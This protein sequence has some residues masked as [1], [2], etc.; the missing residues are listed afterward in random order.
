MQGTLMCVLRISCMLEKNMAVL[1]KVFVD[2]GWIFEKEPSQSSLTGTL[3]NAI[4]PS[5]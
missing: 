4:F 1:E 5:F 2:H 3:D